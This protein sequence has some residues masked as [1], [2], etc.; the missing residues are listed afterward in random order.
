MKR[1]A[2]PAAPFLPTLTQVA[3]QWPLVNGVPEVTLSIN[4]GDTLAFTGGY[5]RADLRSRIIVVSG[6]AAWVGGFVDS[7]DGLTQGIKLP[8]GWPYDV[9]PFSLDIQVGGTRYHMSHEQAASLEDRHAAL[10]LGPDQRSGSFR[11]KAVRLGGDATVS[12][13]GSFVCK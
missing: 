11:G 6:N 4:G 10:A 9:G 7:A 8:A 12:I 3:E 5:C 13:S 2:E 1:E